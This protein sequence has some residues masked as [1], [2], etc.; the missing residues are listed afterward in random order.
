MNVERKRAFLINLLFFSSIALLLFWGIQYA[1]GLLL[2]FLIGL[3][4]AF[5]LKPVIRMISKVLHIKRKASAVLTILAV[6]AL[7]CGLIWIVGS[8]LFVQLTIFFRQIPTLFTQ[9]IWPV[10]EHTAQELCGV[11]CS[12]TGLA[13]YEVAAFFQ[14]KLPELVTGL[15]SWALNFL[16]QIVSKLP[17]AILAIVFS[18]IS[19][20]FISLDYNN[21]L[22]FLTGQIPKKFRSWLFEIKDFMVNT[23]FRL[24]RAYIILMAITFIELTIGLLILRVPMALPAAFLIAFA[25]FLPLIGTGGVLIPW[26]LFEFLRGNYTFAISLGLIYAIMAVVRNIIEPKIVGGQVGLHPLVTLFSMYVGL[27]LFAFAGMILMPM[28]VLIAKMLNDT[29]KLHLWRYCSHETE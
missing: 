25:D 16:S 8:W 26:V 3:L 1:F 6:Y 7:F 5:C 13:D 22:A 9:S 12:A 11:I 10:L 14:E 28:L 29:G 23:A 21:V 4:I 17:S 18:I 15:S 27:K 2:P 19:S 24:I 20:I